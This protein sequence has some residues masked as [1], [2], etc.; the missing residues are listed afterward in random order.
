MTAIAF[1]NENVK[2]INEEKKAENIIT[3][4]AKQ[5]KTRSDKKKLKNSQK[6]FLL[7]PEVWPFHTVVCAFTLKAQLPT[8][9]GLSPI[10]ARDVTHSDAHKS[11]R[12]QWG[13]SRN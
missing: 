7:E 5:W 8:G 11:R 9:S 2:V 1:Q 3:T 4:G 12:A 13:D 6:N 10:A